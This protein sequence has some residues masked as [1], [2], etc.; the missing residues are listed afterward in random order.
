MK[1]SMTSKKAPA[2]E[3]VKLPEHR[4]GVQVYAGDA[5]YGHPYISEVELRGYVPLDAI[6][7]VIQLDADSG[8]LRRTYVAAR[9]AGMPQVLVYQGNRA[10]RLLCVLENVGGYA[11]CVDVMAEA[12]TLLLHA[13]K[14]TPDL[15]AM[16]AA[17]VRQGIEEWDSAGAVDGDPD[18]DGEYVEV[19]DAE[20]V[21]EDEDEAD[22]GE[23]VEEYD[24]E[25]IDSDAVE[26]D[27]SAEDDGVDDDDDAEY[28]DDDAEYE[29]DDAEYEDDED[30][31]D[32]GDDEDETQSTTDTIRAITNVSTLQHAAVSAGISK[33][34]IT[35]AGKSVKKLQ[36]LLIAKALQGQD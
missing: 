25:D 26:D 34:E 16:L 24:E 17:A 23:E 31:E 4:L 22:A 18:D 28:E 6:T 29:D 8:E 2:S 13:T 30:D 21:F 11:F 15:P 7:V 3:V 36:D 5:M 33:A 20:E 12:K 1:D 10:P 35:A 27:D 9:E 19:T 14:P 32:E